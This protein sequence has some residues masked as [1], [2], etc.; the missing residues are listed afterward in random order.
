MFELSYMPVCVRFILCNYALWYDV[1][2]PV[3]LKI[4]TGGCQWT[5]FPY[6]NRNSNEMFFVRLQIKIH[7]LFNDDRSWSVTVVVK[8][9]VAML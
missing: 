9:L 1:K 3:D 2:S 6:H 5:S 4:V 8:I 7:V